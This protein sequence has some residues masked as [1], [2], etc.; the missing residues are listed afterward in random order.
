[1]PEDQ[2]VSRRAYRTIG[3]FFH[4]EWLH[5]QNTVRSVGIYAAFGFIVG[6]CLIVY[7]KQPKGAPWKWDWEQLKH[8][9]AEHI[10]IGLIVSSVAV[11]L[12]EWRAHAKQLHDLARRLLDVL[13]HESRASFSASMSRLLRIDSSLPDDPIRKIYS[14]VEQL[15]FSL[16]ELK[17]GWGTVQYVNFLHG[18]LSGVVGENAETL[19]RL[20]ERDEQTFSVPRT[21]A[22]IA[23]EIL[24]AQ[25]HAAER[26]DCYDVISDFPSW[27]E[28]QLPKFTRET[29]AAIRKGVKVRRI[30][31]LCNLEHDEKFMQLEQIPRILREHLELMERSQAGKW[32]QRGRR[33]KYEVK[34][35]DSENL[36]H[37]NLQA[38]D[39]ER[40]AASHFGVFKHR[41]RAA[42][43]VLVLFNVRDPYLSEL[44]LSRDPRHIRTKLHL[45]DAAWKCDRVQ[46]LSEAVI[47][48]VERKIERALGKHPTHQGDQLS[49]QPKV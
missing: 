40:L 3:E 46:T 36:R 7:S 1:M 25:M 5:F 19:V 33:G 43:E 30:F 45:F 22:H 15:V 47:L 34:V 11:F 26:G 42:D 13:E 35:L 41:E 12:Y 8:L 4:S 9:S 29:E 39:Q 10:G 49:G 48:N 14:G 27:R 18:L 31:S 44:G 17:Q 6:L 28:N 37:T 23:D 2:S 16:A 32:P 38:F 21:A 24:A 20:G